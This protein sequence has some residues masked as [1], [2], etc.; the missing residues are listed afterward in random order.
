MDIYFI[1]KCVAYFLV[2]IMIGMGIR[3][4]VECVK[5]NKDV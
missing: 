2:G 1:A 5:E 3:G 4:F